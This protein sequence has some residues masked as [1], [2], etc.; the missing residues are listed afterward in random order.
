MDTLNFTPTQE[1]VSG[2][3]AH[4]GGLWPCNAG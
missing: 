3:G 4:A 1:S 2:A